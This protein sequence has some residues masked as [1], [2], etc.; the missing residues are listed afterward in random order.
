VSPL[1]KMIAFAT[2]TAALTAVLVAT[3]TGGDVGA[4]ATYRAVFTDASG[5]KTG[6]DVRILGVRVGTVTTVDVTDNRWAEVEFD[7]EADR[8]IP[9][10]ATAT[11][12]YRNLVGQRYLALGMGTGGAGEVLPPGATIPLERTQPALNLTVLFDG[13]KPLFVALSPEDMNTLAFEL[14]QVLQGE[15]ATV[16][17]VLR[18]TATL[19][20]TVANRDKVIGELI[21]NLNTVL[22]TALSPDGVA[23][24]GDTR[25]SE[26]STLI[27]QLQQ[28][29]SG[30]AADREPIGEAVS[31]LGSLTETTAGLLAETRPALKENIAALGPLAETLNRH[32]SLLDGMLAGLEARADA[33]TR[34]VSYGSWLNF[35][36][37]RLS[38]SVGVS[39]LDIRMDVLPVPNTELPERCGP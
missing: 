24:A 3:V 16:D 5:L 29:V 26:L 10:S 6:D 9:A 19:T 38:G 36:L 14:I 7:I 8:T 23:G 2:I 18:H 31:A 37:C 22:D 30:L 35:Y 32:E 27:V 25:G 13:F 1:I 34:A 12:K 20:A 17:S 21:S 15:G 4:R 39:S 11:I 33:F 28:V